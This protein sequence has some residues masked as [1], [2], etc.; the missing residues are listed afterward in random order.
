MAATV[1]H[2]SFPVPTDLS[3]CYVLAIL[4]SLSFPVC[5][6]PTFP[7]R[8]R[9]GKGKGRGREG[10]GIG[11]VNGRGM[12]GKGKYQ[13]FRIFA[14]FSRNFRNNFRENFRYFRNFRKEIFAKS[15]NKFSRNFRENTKTKIF[16]STL[17]HIEKALQPLNIPI[18]HHTTLAY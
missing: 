7:G 17:I 12:E 9:E 6:I 14:K 16:V 2:L 5:T 18:H 1:S 10:E 13:F 8:G 4:S 15:E 11:K 3:F